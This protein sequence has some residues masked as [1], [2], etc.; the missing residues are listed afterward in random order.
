MSWQIDDFLSMIFAAPRAMRTEAA[1]TYEWNAAGT[2]ERML[3]QPLAPETL[4]DFKQA[5][6]LRGED[7]ERVLD[8]FDPKRGGSIGECGSAA[9]CPR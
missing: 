3:Q 7:W 4:A 6:L 5:A 2:L 9:L 1:R 8:C